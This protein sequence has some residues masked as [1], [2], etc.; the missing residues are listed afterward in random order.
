M[1]QIDRKCSRTE[2]SRSEAYCRPNQGSN[3]GGTAVA[4]DGGDG[5]GLGPKKRTVGAA[6]N[7]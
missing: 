3:N 2:R 1:R 4:V 7:C 6:T 5:P